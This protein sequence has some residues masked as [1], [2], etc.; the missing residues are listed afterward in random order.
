MV[1]FNDTNNN[2]YS[3]IRW[4]GGGKN[5]VFDGQ[6]VQRLLQE[7]KTK[8]LM[9]NKIQAPSSKSVINIGTFAGNGKLHLDGSHEEKRLPEGSDTC[10]LAYAKEEQALIFH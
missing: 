5:H 4:E 9:L 10:T 2:T 8:S 3:I 7:E 1:K 6:Q